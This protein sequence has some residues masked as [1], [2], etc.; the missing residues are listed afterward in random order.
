MDHMNKFNKGR[1][2]TKIIQSVRIDVENLFGEH[3]VSSFKDD[4]ISL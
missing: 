3:S 4:V 2:S 1:P